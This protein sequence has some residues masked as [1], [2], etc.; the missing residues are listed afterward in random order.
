MKLFA[1]LEHYSWAAWLA[2]AGEGKAVN[3]AAF[4]PWENLCHNPRLLLSHFTSSCGRA[5]PGGAQSMAAA[6]HVSC[7]EVCFL[8]RTVLLAAKQNCELFLCSLTKPFERLI[9]TTVRI[10]NFF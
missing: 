2:A 5:G 10:L 1:L 7:S 9:N 3:G 6:L 4:P 8:Q